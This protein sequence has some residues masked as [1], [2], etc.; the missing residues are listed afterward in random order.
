MAVCLCREGYDPRRFMLE[1][2]FCEQWFHGSCVQLN[3]EKAFAIAKFACPSCTNK[4]SQTKFVAQ[5]KPLDASLLPLPRQ[6]ASLNIKDVLS[7]QTAASIDK[8]SDRFHQ[9]LE[10]GMFAR[11]GIRHLAG[12]NL[13]AASVQINGFQEP[14]LVEEAVGSV[15]GLQVPSALI[16]A[17]DL[18]NILVSASIIKTIDVALQEARPISYPDAMSMSNDMLG[19]SDWAGNL[20]FPI[21]ET[22]LEYQITPPQVVHDLDWFQQQRGN[23]ADKKTNPNSFVAMYGRHT[24]RDFIIN[25]SGSSCW[26]HHLYGLPLTVYCIP[27]TL[28]HLDKFVEWTASPTR[29]SIFLGD[30]VDKCIKCELQPNSSLLIPP[31]WIYALYVPSQSSNSLSASSKSEGASSSSPANAAVFTTTFF[32]HGFGMKDQVRVLELEHAMARRLGKPGRPLGMWPIVTSKAQFTAP[33]PEMI[34]TWI[35]PAIQRFIQRLKSLH[36]LTEWEKQGLLH[37][38]PLLRQYDLPNHGDTT[39]EALMALLGA[40]EPLHNAAISKAPK[41]KK[42]TPT[43]AS[44]QNSVMPTPTIDTS[45]SFLKRDKKVCKCHLKKCV[46]C[47]NCIKRHCNCATQ[48]PLPPS[49]KKSAAGTP[50]SVGG[51]GPS[52]ASALDAKKDSKAKKKSTSA[53]PDNM[54][55]PPPPLPLPPSA[56]LSMPQWAEDDEETLRREASSMWELSNDINQ[57]FFSAGE[58]G[59]NMNGA[60]EL[61]DA[62]GIIDMVESSSLFSGYARDDLSIKEES[63]AQT[64]LQPSSLQSSSAAGIPAH[65]PFVFDAA[66]ASV[67][68]AAAAAT[69]YYD[70]EKDGLALDMKDFA[71]GDMTP[72]GDGSV[73]H[74]ASCHRC[75]NLRKKNVRCLGCPHIFCQ[76]CAEKMVEEHGAQ[77]F[78]GGCPVCKEMCCCGKNR[79]TV[80]RRKFHCYKKCPA[81][82]RCNLLTDDLIKRGGDDSFKDDDMLMEFGLDED[83]HDMETS[84]HQHSMMTMPSSLVGMVPTPFPTATPSSLSD[85]EFEMDLGDLDPL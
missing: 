82:K 33:S 12:A 85:C 34:L 17:D 47:R 70:T 10:S 64:S 28:A 31:S 11:S 71:S 18:P 84:N 55:R 3:E 78:I 45:R 35:W 43:A 73:R 4:G 57:S 50:S 53:L 68:V 66:G 80:C 16:H 65:H 36:V 29:R 15:P 51:A 23:A 77:T 56:A 7:T 46:N 44:T 61:D 81:T 2:A 22:S 37:V 83:M 25:S 24:F 79:S 75:G 39:I 74:R 41:A 76:K 52:T 8:S 72:D 60:L 48:Q 59:L 69:D 32:F 20:E 30:L 63:L 42:P 6:F 1:C 62:F 67:A 21:V 40:K 27:P 9:V 58:L 26:I 5:T 38:L 54:T 14:I 49:T 19:D 13:T